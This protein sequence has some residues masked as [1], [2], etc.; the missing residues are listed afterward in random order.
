M[1]LDGFAALTLLQ[2]SVFVIDYAVSSR[3]HY[4]AGIKF[5]PT[6]DSGLTF[7]PWECIDLVSKEI[8]NQLVDSDISFEDSLLPTLFQTVTH[9]A[10]CRLVAE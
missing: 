5:S 1:I 3:V 10:I 4:N 8:E 2:F 7:D 9:S 6:I